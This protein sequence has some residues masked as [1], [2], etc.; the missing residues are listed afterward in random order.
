[1]KW[2]DTAPLLKMCSDSSVVVTLFMRK[3]NEKFSQSYI[4][5]ITQTPSK[6]RLGGGSVWFYKLAIF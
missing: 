5:L 4:S 1:M 6:L 3:F 2:H